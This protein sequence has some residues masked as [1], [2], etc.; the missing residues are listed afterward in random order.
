MTTT[1]NLTPDLQQLVQGR[2]RDPFG[3]LGRHVRDGKALVR[4]YLPH[5]EAVT[6]A[7][8]EHAMQ[9]V[10]GTGIFEWHGDP[11]QVPPCYRLIWR[12]DAH[13]EHARATVAQVRVDLRFG[14][15]RLEG[16]PARDVACRRPRGP[17]PK[18]ESNRR[19]RAGSSECSAWDP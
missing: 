11:A 18:K 15:D 8:G 10:P 2:H 14:D 19:G 1:P 12:D 7:E 5:A 16:T 17:Q 13:R 4:V 9:Q 6:I 3:I